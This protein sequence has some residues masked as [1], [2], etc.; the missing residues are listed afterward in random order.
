M[1]EPLRDDV[2]VLPLNPGYSPRSPSHKRAR[3]SASASPSVLESAS[4]SPR[5]PR[6][7]LALVTCSTSLTRSTA[8][9]EI[10]D[11]NGITAQSTTSVDTESFVDITGAGGPD[12]SSQVPDVGDFYDS[13]LAAVSSDDGVVLGS[14]NAGI[15][16][17]WNIDIPDD[18]IAPDT[19]GVRGN[20]A[21]PNV[22]AN[23]CRRAR[24]VAS[25]L[26]G[27]EYEHLAFEETH[28]PQSF[29]NDARNETANV[30]RMF[31]DLFMT[32]VVLS[33]LILEVERLTGPCLTYYLGICARP[34]VRWS[35]MPTA[36]GNHCRHHQYMWIVTAGEHVHIR[37]LERCL[38]KHLKALTGAQACKHKSKGGE[39][40]FETN[41]AF[42]YVV[43]TVDHLFFEDSGSK[44]P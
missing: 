39:P 37:Y 42:L 3:M 1:S 15:I 22:A 44:Q 9:T 10:D 18:A 23:S 24:V 20:S 8:P 25:A 26:D 32:N 30:T 14:D 11:N 41:F 12:D 34:L 38:I 40:F 21:V 27:P 43:G 19:P 2:V 16:Q 4:F 13:L 6:S 28:A 7:P 17:F 29:V 5:V 35:G 36:S 31:W 33:T